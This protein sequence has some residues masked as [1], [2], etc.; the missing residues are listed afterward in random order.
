MPRTSSL[1]AF[2]LANDNRVLPCK[3][4]LGDSEKRSVLTC[5]HIW[6]PWSGV[7][8]LKSSC[9][10]GWRWNTWIGL[11]TLS[12]FDIEMGISLRSQQDEIMEVLS[13]QV[14]WDL[15]LIWPFVCPW[16]PS[17]EIV[18]DE[19]RLVSWWTYIMVIR[20][21]ERLYRQISLH[22]LRR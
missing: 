18:L 21:Y 4:V 19:F 7:C 16:K 15:S 3:L 14:W 22:M 8:R 13:I 10:D 1:V 9:M 5:F 6:L 12:V 17:T 2:W 20:Q 11:V